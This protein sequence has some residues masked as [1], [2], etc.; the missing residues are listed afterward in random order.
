MEE[1]L[2]KSCTTYCDLF[3][4]EERSIIVKVRGTS[5]SRISESYIRRLIKEA[6]VNEVE[7]ATKLS[8]AAED[9][10]KQLPD[11]TNIIARAKKYAKGKPFTYVRDVG[12]DYVYAAIGGDLSLDN[13]APEYFVCVFDGV[14]KDR[15]TLG[16]KFVSGDQGYRPMKIED[17]RTVDPDVFNNMSEDQKIAV[18]NAAAALQDEYKEMNTYQYIVFKVKNR[19]LPAGELIAS[20]PP[21]DEPAAVQNREGVVATVATA[22]GVTGETAGEVDVDVDDDGD[23]KPDGTPGSGP[24]PILVNPKPRP[25]WKL[26]FPRIPWFKRKPKGD[27]SRGDDDDGDEDGRRE[28]RE[29]RRARKEREKAEKRGD[30]ERSKASAERWNEAWR[31]LTK[32]E[33]KLF[34]ALTMDDPNIGKI[35][36]EA[37]KRGEYDEIRFNQVLDTQ[38]PTTFMPAGEGVLPDGNEVRTF[39][40]YVNFRD[41]TYSI[42]RMQ[43]MAMMSGTDFARIVSKYPRLI[44][45]MEF[46]GARSVPE[47]GGKIVNPTSGPFK[48][49]FD[50]LK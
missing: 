19:T 34:V 41:N 21:T 37:I 47:E 44:R 46:G 42:Y 24:S 29:R 50:A 1:Y 25:W 9:V 45:A 14:R 16:Y 4:T 8:Q 31:G 17:F 13:F 32:S 6:V 36:A 5:M 26:K 18:E 28:E 22:P 33:R 39:Q 2:Q 48:D 7:K 3:G 49:L 15:A 10:I 20:T 12:D 38:Y 23:G 40:G 43:D 27:P 35:A 30:K 11:G